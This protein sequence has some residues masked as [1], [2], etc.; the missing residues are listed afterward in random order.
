MAATPAE[1]AEALERLNGNY[2][3]FRT[4]ELMEACNKKASFKVQLATLAKSLRQEFFHEELTTKNLDPDSPCFAMRLARDD[5]L[6]KHVAGH[7]SE[8]DWKRLGYYNFFS[9]D[10][11]Y[12]QLYLH[13]VRLKNE[14]ELVKQEQRESSLKYQKIDNKARNLNRKVGKRGWK[15]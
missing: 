7:L 6:K 1:T 8:R 14:Y 9:E 2:I 12:M 5:R 11:P 15:R 13:D 4:Q 10:S 3:Y